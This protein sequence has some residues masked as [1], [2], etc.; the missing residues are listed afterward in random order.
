M[1]VIMGRHS[2]CFAPERVCA[3]MAKERKVSWSNVDEHGVM[4]LSNKNDIHDKLK[5]DLTLLFP[6][7]LSM[8]DSQKYIVEFGTKQ[9]LSDDYASIEDAGDKISA[10]AVGW[11]CLLTGE[12]SP[13]RKK[14]KTI[15]DFEKAVEKA[16][17]TVDEYQ[18]YVANW[19]TLSDDDKRTA[20]KF[21][22]NLSVLTKDLVKAQKALTNAESKLKAEMAK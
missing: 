14:D 13:R 17:A 18:Q 3:I 11:N 10:A 12:K 4:I 8:S 2:W 22:R 15:E 1:A 20:A 16:Q 19:A 6:D 7:F 21:G 5:I 9:S